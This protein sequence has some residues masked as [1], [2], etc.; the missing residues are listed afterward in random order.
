[1]K[2]NKMNINCVCALI[3]NEYGQILAVS[4]KYNHY[5]LGLPGGKIE[6]EETLQEALRREVMEETGLNVIEFYSEN[7]FDCKVDDK[8]FC[9]TYFVTVWKGKLHSNEAAI[10]KWVKF[11]EIIDGSSFS[12]YNAALYEYIVKNHLYVVARNLDCSL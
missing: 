4:R 6:G 8:N 5:D 12:K 7:H 1:M 3:R 11:K 10:V 2:E 9:R